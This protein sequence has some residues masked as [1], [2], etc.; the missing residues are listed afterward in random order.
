[1]VSLYGLEGLGFRGVIKMGVGTL[2]IRRDLMGGSRLGVLTTLL[3]SECRVGCCKDFLR[4]GPP[5]L[6][7]V[8]QAKQ[9]WPKTPG[10]GF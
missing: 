7:G 6:C 1:M 9:H 4:F 2:E 5:P 10:E 8:N 3:I